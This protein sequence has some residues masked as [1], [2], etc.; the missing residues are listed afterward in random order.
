MGKNDSNISK[1]VNKGHEKIKQ[2]MGYLNDICFGK[3]HFTVAKTLR[4]TIF[5]SSILLN[6]E[7]WYS[8]TK[9]NVEDLEKVDNALMNRIFELPSS[10]PAAFLHLEMS[11]LPIRFILM[12]RR[13]NFLQ[14][15]L[16]ED[17]DSLLNRF[18]MAQME[19]TFKGDWWETV[20][21]DMVDL[22]LDMSLFEISNM[23]EELFKSKVKDCVNKAAHNWLMEQ[24]M[25]SK[26]IKDIQYEEHNK[27]QDYLLSENLSVSQRKFLIHL[28]CKM[29]KVRSNY[30]GMYES[31][32]CQLCSPPI[33]IDQPLEDSQEHLMLC[34]S[35]SANEPIKENTH[36]SDIFSEDIEKQEY[37]T[38]I[39]EQKFKL[40]K[41]LLKNMKQ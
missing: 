24:K 19:E 1:R 17:E 28:R 6:S 7:S 25:K 12:Q 5:L 31:K 11:T 39:L 36:Y 14:Y 15:I 34:S 13:L 2:I 30:S 27:I 22:D 40:R 16:K 32:Y 35:L 21:Q 3:Y 37:V 8:L 4:E 41:K 9:Q 38:L 20:Q 33:L 18:L 26:K 23:S 10:T 29:V